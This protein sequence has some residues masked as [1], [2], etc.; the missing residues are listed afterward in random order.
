[1]STSARQF[2][3]WINGVGLVSACLLSG[4]LVIVK[5]CWADALETTRLLDVLSAA[6]CLLLAAHFFRGTAALPVLFGRRARGWKRIW[7][8]AGVLAALSVVPQVSKITLPLLFVVHVVMFFYT[9]LYSI[10]NILFQ[11][12]LFHLAVARVAWWPEW[13]GWV[14]A[15][16]M[17]PRVEAASLNALF[18]SLG[19]L[20]YSAGF[21]KL[22]SPLWRKGEGTLQF[23]RQRHL[24]RPFFAKLSALV[25]TSLFV[26]LG[27]LV[28]GAELALLPAFFS[29]A[30]LL[31][32]AIVLAAFSFSLFIVTDI[33]F[34][35]QILVVQLGVLIWTVMSRG[36][37]LWLGG[38]EPLHGEDWVFL[39]SAFVTCIAV[40]LPAFSN[41]TGIKWLQHLGNGINTPISVFT[42]AH[43][44]GVMVYR[45]R[46]TAE[47]CQIPVP[48]IFTEEGT[49]GTLQQQRPR[50]LQ[51]SMYLVGR[52]V[53]TAA[54]DGVLSPKDED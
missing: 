18:V 13:A 53:R 29:P 32:I 47:G 5:P 34:I 44:E 19:I 7:Y 3:P 11:N 43:Q 14:P 39:T 21:E 24:I 27:Y 50:Y 33:S 30:A 31:P 26:G 46:I 41:R 51:S 8:L 36:G 12:S 37:P 40:H 22:K 45:F 1:M 23:F 28:H 15:G 4:F 2:P 49:P 17:V 42:E 54:R 6:L 9:R 10:E 35:G 52:I 25:P 16:A 48:Q 20:M 38:S